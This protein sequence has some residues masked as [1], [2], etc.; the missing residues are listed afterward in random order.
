MLAFVF[1]ALNLAAAYNDIH[2]R[3]TVDLPAEWQL[4]P[5]PGDTGGVTFRRVREKTLAIVS[6]RVVAVKSVT[7]DAYVKRLVDGS[8][9][10]QGYRPISGD[11]DTL[12]GQPAYKRKFGLDVDKEGKIKKIVE[13]RI[14]VVNGF[15]YI[16]H[17]ESLDS[18]FDSFADDFKHFADTFQP[19]SGETGGTTV[20]AAQRSA[21]VG[22]WRM[23][24]EPTTTLVLN[25]NGSLTMGNLQGQYRVEGNKLIVQL[26]GSVQETFTWRKMGDS[27][28]LSSQALGADVIKYKKQQ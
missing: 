20:M 16:L 21:I 11:N 24:S 10:E 27:L 22:I 28:T 12:A 7:L 23:E 5:M 25:P 3:F 8:S 13:E 9:K 1:A 14:V 17:T 6:I 18:T 2:E 15:G 19:K 4:A 26:N